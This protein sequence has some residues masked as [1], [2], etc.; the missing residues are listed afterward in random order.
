MIRGTV[1]AWWGA[2]LG[3]VGTGLSIWNIWRDKPRIK[4]SV[5]KNM[6]LSPNDMT[7]NPKEKFIIITA[8]NVGRYPA[9]LYKAYFT[10][11][12]SRSSIKSLLLLGPRNFGTGIL[13]PGLKRDFPG[14][15]SQCDLS[16]LKEAYV[17]DAVEHKFRCKIPR[18]WRK[19]TIQ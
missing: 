19:K 12:S 13:Y 9:H 4:V 2:I 10:L 1:I 3:T 18:S 7:D 5:A 15:Q 11:R 6:I 8:A 17:V 14:I 16:N